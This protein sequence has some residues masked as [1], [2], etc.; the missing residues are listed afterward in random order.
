MLAVVPLRAF[1]TAKTRLD[2]AVSPE[3]RRR[4]AAALAERVVAACR[5]SGWRVVV[6]TGA[7]DVSAWC[8][9]HGVPR[10]ADPGLGLDAAAEAGIA[11]AAGPW[12]V[13]HGDL[14]LI[15]PEDLFGIADAAA[16]GQVVLAP[17][18][19]GGTN[20]IS[21]LSPIRFAYG[22]G[23]FVRHLAATPA[24][25]LVVVRS[26]LAV[27]LDTSADLAAVLGHPRGAW[28]GALLS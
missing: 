12:M 23:S 10:L 24:P 3:A 9:A 2:P 8:D 27:E 15:T 26:G 22:P 14:P 19:D 17:A 20:V 16:A 11:G 25:H 5:D 18:R 1:G 4:I 6:V 7:E 13:V 21:A 28:L